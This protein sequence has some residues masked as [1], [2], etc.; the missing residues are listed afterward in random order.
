[1][2]RNKK[3]VTMMELLAVVV[4]MG[5]LVAASIPY[6]SG[7]LRNAKITTVDTEL[8]AT[9]ASLKQH[10][11]AN[12]GVPLDIQ[13]LNKLSDQIFE[14]VPKNAGETFDTY[15]TKS[16]LD[17]WNQSYYLYVGSG[18]Q[19]YMI[20]HSYGPDGIRG[21]DNTTKAVGDDILSIYY[22]K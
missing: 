2:F 12:A 9:M 17:P 7:Y 4:I 20:L 3:G 5:I 8:N 22:P 16:K 10:Y 21:L 18:S 11:V 1:L 14:L 13:E 19:N 15:K 6:I